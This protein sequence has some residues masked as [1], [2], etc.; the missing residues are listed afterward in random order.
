MNFILRL[1]AFLVIVCSSPSVLAQTSLCFG[2][3][4]GTPC[5]CGNSGSAGRGCANSANPIGAVVVATG[6]F[7]VGA[8]TLTL[9]ATGGLSSGPVLFFQGSA[10]LAGGLGVVF[11]DGLLCVSGT[12]KRL[13]VKFSDLSGTAVY[14]VGGDNSVS[15]QGMVMP[16]DVRYYQV[17]YRDSAAFC[18]ASTSNMTQA[19]CVT[20]TP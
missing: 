2:D 4:T 6:T 13:S 9:T 16:A 5:P 15:V 20:W 11:N 10:I 8:D 3:G 7:R 1:A 19:I 18:T 17:F 14:P 12:I